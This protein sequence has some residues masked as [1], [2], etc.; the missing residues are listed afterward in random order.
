MR[1]LFAK[2][3]VWFWLALSL[4][5]A[6]A[7]VSML[8]ISGSPEA[9]QRRWA[10][11]VGAVTRADGERMAEALEREGAEAVPLTSG[12]RGPIPPRAWLFSEQGELIAGDPDERLM[13]LARAAC[14]DP[15][16][17]VFY[18]QDSTY[19]AVRVRGPSGRVYLALGE[20][21]P[22][23]GGRPGSRGPRGGVGGPSGPP[24]GAPWPAI[25]GFL[26]GEPLLVGTVLGAVL[27]TAGGVCFGLA[28][29]LTRPLRELQATA[30]RIAGGDLDVRVRN[31]AAR[32]DEIGQLGR[33]FNRM[34]G[35][36][37]DLIATQQRLLR[38]I[39]HEL[40][41]PLARLQVALDL[42]RKQ[43]EGANSEWLDRIERECGRLNEMIGESLRL[44]RL[45][46]EEVGAKHEPIELKALLGELVA[47]SDFE[48][49]ANGRGVQ[50]DAGSSAVVSGSANLLRSAFENVLRNAIRH[51][52]P[53]TVVDVELTTGDVN[54]QVRVSIR[55]RGP[56]VPEAE[57]A[58]I[59][60]PFYRAAA[61]RER[62]TGGVGLG[63]SI[64][65]RVIRAHGGT[66]V[67]TNALGGGLQIEVYLPLAADS[68][69]RSSHPP[70][71]V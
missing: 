2:I 68:A 63:L 65:Q 20:F 56:G 27:L 49:R 10:A 7:A 59:F 16:R 36:V 18:E 47:D 38:D 39:S 69:S 28:R 9:E 1:S 4:V 54:G 11:L 31:A 6:A 58:A 50:L 52:E 67:A 71:M 40:R 37:E 15:T 21:R 34:A 12:M 13:R 55:D 26:M 64:A 44:V 23:M 48:A 22:E 29:Y 3:F 24:R 70:V 53:G 5:A 41:S 51:T 8:W 57:L 14:Q 42:A 66:I 19:S 32:R 60:R 17:E 62:E 43:P 30:N 46:H 61:A 45:E 25:A 33:D 35:K